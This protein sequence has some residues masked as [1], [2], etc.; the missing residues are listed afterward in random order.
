MRMA[1]AKHNSRTKGAN[2]HCEGSAYETAA[3]T[4]ERQMVAE[5]L[6]KHVAILKCQE[7]PS[8]DRASSKRIGHGIVTLDSSWHG[9]K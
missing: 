4:A 2:P 6:K 1:V 9:N 5:G 3:R 8:L 7:P